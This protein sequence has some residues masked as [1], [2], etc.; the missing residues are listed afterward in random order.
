MSKLSTLPIIG[1]A[2]NSFQVPGT[3]FS[4]HATG[5]NYIASLVK[6]ANCFAVQIPSMGN[7]YNYAE[8]IKKLD[9]IMLTG[10]RANVEPYHYG[11]KPFPSDEVIDPARDTTVLNLIP[12]CIEAGKPILGIC[13]GLQEINVA[14]GGTIHYRV[15]LLPDKNDH[16][17]PQGLSNLTEEIF[18]LKHAI[19][20]PNGGYF[21]KLINKTSCMVNSLHGQGIDRLGKGLKI[22]AT[23]DDGLIEA[24]SVIDHPNFAI[25]VQ[26]HAEFMPDLHTNS[27]SRRLF[28]EF[29]QAAREHCR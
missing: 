9:G 6:Y 5:V 21:H 11:G 1:V 29:G 12:A 20:F 28:E 24:I 4:S 19:N 13:R 22:E 15:H 3:T 14:L 10:G 8:F 18:A 16:R 27:L 7:A 26:W 23:S 17:M 2:S 25:G